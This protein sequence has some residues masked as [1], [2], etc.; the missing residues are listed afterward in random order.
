MDTI[1]KTMNSK[2]EERETRKN[3]ATAGNVSLDGHKLEWKAGGDEK[4][5]VSS[6]TQERTG[7]CVIAWTHFHSFDGDRRDGECFSSAED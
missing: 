3:M 4:E 2:W 5:Q 1:T 7:A 6:R